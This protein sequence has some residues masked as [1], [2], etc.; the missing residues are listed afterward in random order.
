[1]IAGM[2]DTAYNGLFTLTTCPTP[3][4][5][6]FALVHANEAETTDLGGVIDDTQLKAVVTQVY[7]QDQELCRK[8]FT[9]AAGTTATGLI[10]G[11]LPK[12]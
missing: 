7:F 3:K 10:I 6:S 11:Y 8:I 4:T 5:F 12:L 1:M 9:T 2:T